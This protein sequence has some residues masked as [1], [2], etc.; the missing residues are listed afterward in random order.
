MTDKIEILSRQIAFQKAGIEAGFEPTKAQL[1]WLE[2]ATILLDSLRALREI[3]WQS[4]SE[5][6]C[7]EIA[8][9]VLI[10]HN[11]DFK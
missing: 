4:N 9:K 3:V 11:I 1:E 5:D 8:S 7:N 2:N 6:E 10:D